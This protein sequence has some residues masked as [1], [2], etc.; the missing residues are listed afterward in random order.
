MQDTKYAIIDGRLCVAATGE[1]IPDDEPLFILRAK[2]TQ[3]LNCIWEYWRGIAM[4]APKSG[5]A[6]SILERVRLFDEFA[7]KHPDRM[8]F[9]DTAE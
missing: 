8:K 1:P 6:S 3:A 7:K 4:R 9:P 2:D 5:L